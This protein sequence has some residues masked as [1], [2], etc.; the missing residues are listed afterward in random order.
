MKEDNGY[1]LLANAIIAKATE[2]YKLAL[3]KLTESEEKLKKSEE[4]L[5]DLE[6]KIN[7]AREKKYKA[8]ESLAAAKGEIYSLEEFFY[9]G[10]FTQLSGG[11][12]S[13][14]YIIKRI[15]KEREA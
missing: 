11:T 14:D 3:N 2:D 13:P 1:E 5:K 10:W 12:V 6:G 4:Y 8:K 7:N 9:S 15:K